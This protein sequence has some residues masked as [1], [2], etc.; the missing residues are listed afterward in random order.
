MA[1]AIQFPYA[2]DRLHTSARLIGEIVERRRAEE[3]LAVTVDELWRFDRLAVGREERM[4]E[5]KREVNEM[6]RKA[7]LSPP[8]DSALV[9]AGQGVPG[10]V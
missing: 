1:G 10:D 8:Y 5:L 7:G 6:A 3:E 4:I 2:K 9:E